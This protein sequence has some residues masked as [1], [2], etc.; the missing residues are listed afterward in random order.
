MQYH[1]FAY[2][3]HLFYIRNNKQNMPIKSLKKCP[4]HEANI[5]LVL[6][7]I[8]PKS[9]LSI[10]IPN[11]S[12]ITIAVLPC[13]KCIKENKTEVAIIAPGMPANLLNLS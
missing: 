7:K 1:E 5:F 6:A 10:N 13:E 12:K 4:V 3:C 2:L 11:K 9:T 8:I